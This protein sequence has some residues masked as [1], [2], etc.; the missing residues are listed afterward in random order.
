MMG[1]LDWKEGAPESVQKCE[2]QGDTKKNEP[3]PPQINTFG[4]RTDHALDD[5]VGDMLNKE[6]HV[7]FKGS[8]RTPEI[9]PQMH[10]TGAPQESELT[11]C[12]LN[13]LRDNVEQNLLCIRILSHETFLELSWQGHVIACQ[14]DWGMRR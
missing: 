6:G 1:T 14:V 12:C 9:D 10:E 3:K 5:K 13:S 2:R 7:T 11:L 4:G 8:E